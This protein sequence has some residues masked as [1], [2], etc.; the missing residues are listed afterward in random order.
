MGRIVSIE[1]LLLFYL[2][3]V[4]FIVVF[5]IYWMFFQRYDH[6]VH[7]RWVDE[8]L[9][10]ADG[11]EA[12]MPYYLIRRLRT[13]RGLLALGEAAEISVR[14]CKDDFFSYIQENQKVLLTYAFRFCRKDKIRSAYFAYLTAIL[15]LDLQRYEKGVCLRDWL[16]NCVVDS[17]V[18]VRENALKAIY[19]SGDAELVISAL[20]LMGCNQIV[21]NRKLITDGLCTYKGDKEQLADQLIAAYNRFSIDYKVDIIDFIRLAGI[22]RQ[23]ELSRFFTEEDKDIEIECALIRYFRKYPYENV[24]EELIKYLLNDKKWETASQAALALGEYPGED[25]VNALK[26]SICSYNWYVRYNS[27]ESLARLHLSDND[28]L[29]LLNGEDKYA[30]EQLRYHLSLRE[31]KI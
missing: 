19:V 20:K 11:D 4:V 28:I 17:S 7:D 25:T 16:L 15:K 23:H 26:K 6:K 18:Y 8:W 24:K 21:H 5:D 29:D 1:S 27:A 9:D 30:K 31:E 3:E 2:I 22:K 14:N 13:E 10:W 12:L